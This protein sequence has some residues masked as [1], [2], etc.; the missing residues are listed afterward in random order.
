MSFVKVSTYPC[1]PSTTRGEAS[2]LS[3][4]KDGK[5]VYTNGK[6]VIIRDLKNPSLSLAYTGHAHPVTVARVSPS[7]YYCASADSQGN[8]KIWDTSYL[9]SAFPPTSSEPPILKAE[10]KTLS[11]KIRDLAWDGESKRIIVVGEGREKFGHAFQVDTGSAAGEIGAGHSKFI[12]AVS[13][14]HQRP[15]RAVTG[16]DDGRLVF[17]SG[18]P[19]K[20]E[21]TIQSHTQFIQDVQYSP[22]GDFFASVGSDYKAFVYD[23]KTGDTLFE[24]S[25]PHR[26]SIMAVSWSPSSKLLATSSA[27]CSVKLWDVESKN[28]KATWTIGSGVAH[29]QVGNTWSGESDSSGI[30]SLSLGGQLNVLEVNTPDRVSKVLHGAIKGVTAASI[31]GKTLFA[32]AFD[33]QVTTFNIESGEALPLTGSSAGHEGK[34]VAMA[35]SSGTGS[36]FSAGYDDRIREID[37]NNQSLK[38][39]AYTLTSQPKGIDVV[40]S[41]S[42]TIVAITVN[43]IEVIQD[44]NEVFKLPVNFAPSAV[45]TSKDTTVAIGGEDQKVRLYDWNGQELSEVGKLEANKAAISALAF[46]KDGKLLAVGDSVGKIILYDVAEKKT[47]TTRW[48]YHSARINS[49]SFTSDSKYCLSGSLDTHIYVWSVEKPIRNVG[50]KNAVAGGVNI[51]EWLSQEGQKRLIMGAGADGCIRTWEVTLPA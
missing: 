43:A 10:Y 38:P 46:S 50:I 16:G 39:S 48:A 36:V 35:T 37:P 30:V 42:D 11:G 12:N 3:G 7:G 2:K 19:F 40:A 26:G 1:N 9:T 24:L 47:M 49:L 28:N 5:I 32:G 44:G 21:K 8:V 41:G 18:V 45:A 33:G 15:F 29:Q 25:E 20:Y 4:T 34:V 31:S 23:G 17:H 6:V 22:N 13:I 27:D 14:R 51:V